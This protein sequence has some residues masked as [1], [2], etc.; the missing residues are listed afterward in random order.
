MNKSNEKAQNFLIE[1]YGCQMNFSDS[2]IVTTVLKNEGMS[3]VE[4]IE[5]ADYVFLNTCSI[6]DKAE[7]TVRNRLKAINGYKKKNKNLK[8]GILGCMAERLKKKLLE[9]EKMVDLVAGPDTYRTLPQLLNEVETNKQAIN[10]SFELSETY[11]DLFGAVEKS[12]VNALVTITRGC[13][14]M[15]SFCVVPFTRGRERSRDPQS[16]IDETQ[17][18][19]SKGIKEIS[20]L[21]QNVDSYLWYGGGAKKDFKKVDDF[22]KATAIDFAQLLE[23]VAKHFPEMRIRFTTSNPQDM[24]VDVIE[25]MSRYKNICKSIHLPFQSGNNR[26]LDKM[27]RGYTIEKYMSIVNEIHRQLPTCSISHDIIAGFPTETEEEHRD[28]IKIIEKVGFSAGYMFKYSERQNT[29]AHKNYTDDISEERKQRRLAEII[30]VQQKSSKKFNQRFIGKKTIVLIQ[31][32]AKK[33]KNMWCGRNDQY[34][35][36]VFDK[37]NFNIGDVVEVEIEECTS[38]TLIGK[39]KVTPYKYI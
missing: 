4:E 16:I 26:V 17:N 11:H 1:S 9:E 18:L 7:Q 32:V 8:V 12:R 15:C 39:S 21:G 35:M 27:K 34:I 31:A 2:D 14:N 19:Q 20:L 13:D 36:T 6:R 37:L 30:E 24:T 29:Y 38:T 25:V 23:M 3:K 28:T 33:N 10:T 22:Q 5:K